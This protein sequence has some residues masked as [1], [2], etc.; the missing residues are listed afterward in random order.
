MGKKKILLLCAFT[1]FALMGCS[2]NNP[3]GDIAIKE[4]E[5][6]PGVKFLYA[7]TNLSQQYNWEELALDTS[8]VNYYYY[9]LGTSE[10]NKIT[11]E[12]PNVY[13]ELGSGSYGRLD[14]RHQ[15]KST[16][17]K[18]VK[19]ELSGGELDGSGNHVQFTGDLTE[20]EFFSYTKLLDD[21]APTQGVKKLDLELT[22]NLDYVYWEADYGYKSSVESVEYNIYK[23]NY[24]IEDR[25][26]V[27]Q[28]AI[29]D[30]Y[31][32]HE[33]VTEKS[34]G[35]S[36]IGTIDDSD[37]LINV[38]HKYPN[39]GEKE[40][41]LAEGEKYPI[42]DNYRDL[43]EILDGRNKIESFYEFKMN[44]GLS[45]ILTKEY[46]EQKDSFG[47]NVFNKKYEWYSSKKNT[48]TVT[49]QYNHDVEYDGIY[50]GQHVVETIYVNF[51]ISTQKI[52]NYGYDFAFYF[53]GETIQDMS[54][55]YNY[56]Y[57]EKENYVVPAGEDELFDYNKY[58]DYGTLLPNLTHDENSEVLD[59]KAEE[60]LQQVE[61][62]IQE[63][64][65]NEPTGAVAQTYNF[66]DTQLLPTTSDGEDYEYDV[67]I[68]TTLDSSLY[69][70]NVMVSYFNEQYTGFDEFFRAES[71]VFQ[72]F[73]KDGNTYEIQTFND[74]NS[75]YQT[76]KTTTP[77]ETQ[78]EPTLSL[79]DLELNVFDVI[80]GNQSESMK[81]F[82]NQ[83]KI[84]N[85][86][87]TVQVTA[88]KIPAGV[89][90]ETNE[91]IL[92]HYVITV[93]A[94][95]QQTIEYD[96]QG[97]ATSVQVGAIFTYEIGFQI[98]E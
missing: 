36:L 26:A 70:D 57:G 73:N 20:E 79:F 98:V 25:S 21:S 68:Q 22:D 45:E 47:N 56:T 16:R 29:D 2:D 97:Y 6:V 76:G 96:D 81:Y 42:P 55:V 64:K 61:N 5:L 66:V 80:G 49:L 46:Y 19:N 23:N 65:V 75:S 63:N 43:Y 83:A 39:E 71:G 31:L 32:V 8:L 69:N 10:D 50:A 54:I 84:G 17:V 77:W 14:L 94:A 28:V 27:R 52:V 40:P 72:K 1:A 62:N 7:Y 90:K 48:D 60:L 53:Y 93:Q 82:I 41:E 58:Y 91:E 51:D 3:N 34:R 89:D 59:D 38:N 92:E 37:Y 12:D 4:K 95:R 18:A 87:Y 30:S 13:T 35:R 44:S 88:E 78:S 74:R 9:D 24:M 11:L 86:L 33:E 67:E 15:K 85:P